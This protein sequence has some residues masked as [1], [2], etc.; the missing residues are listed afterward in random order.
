MG[1][2][3]VTID[4]PAGAGKSTVS[5]MLAERLGYRL[6]D[7]GALYRAVAL[8]AERKGV[9]W[10]DGP[11]AAAVAQDLDIDFRMENMKNRVFMGAEEIT[12][13]I[14]EPAI[15]DGASRVSAL[16]EV[17]TALLDLQRRMG[18]AGGVVVEGRDAG[19]VV[20]PDAGAKFFLTAAPEV[21]AHRR[22]V[23]LRNV[24][25]DID[26]TSVLADMIVRD[27]R[28]ESRAAAPLRQAPDAQRVDSIH[29]S[30]D[31]VVAEMERMIRAR[32]N[33]G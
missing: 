8:A 9:S 33:G 14:R 5:R 31:E 19:T 30:V 6:L 1:K 20:F 16:P 28:D 27:H 12:S 4:G 32:E 17:R 15:S 26:E 25:M 23:E 7:T 13:A 3:V 22:W 29:L 21:R 10:D 11:G 24:G 18:S 2:I